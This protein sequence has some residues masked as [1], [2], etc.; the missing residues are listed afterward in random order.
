MIGDIR[1]I[2]ERAC[3]AE[4]NVFGYGIWTHHITK[5]AEHARR[6]APLFGADPEIVEIAAL[7]HDY[8]SVKDEALYEDHH[9]HGPIEA[10]AILTKLG[11]PE[12][13][14]EAVRH[15]IAAHRAS[16]DVERRSAEARCLANA[17]A[18]AHIENVTSLLHL[19]YARWGRGIDEGAA[20]VC[21]KLERSW[22]KLDPRV[23]E[24]AREP[25]EA[26]LMVLD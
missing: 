13:T 14:I 17:D 23:R 18:L 11:C 10:G 24:I 16:V 20:W 1:T 4:T 21:A 9:V 3:A 12:D 6:L 8:A 19:A 26:A 2:V 7:L 25:Y 22:G 5:V 15:A